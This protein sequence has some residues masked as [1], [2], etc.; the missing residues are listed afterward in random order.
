MIAP[1]LGFELPEFLPAFEANHSAGL[2]RTLDDRFR[3][4]EMQ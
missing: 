3:R 2:A 1:L 4:E